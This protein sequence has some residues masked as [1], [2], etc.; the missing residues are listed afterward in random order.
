MAL[1]GFFRNKMFHMSKMIRKYYIVFFV[2]PIFRVDFNISETNI[3]N[4][5]IGQDRI[6][7]F[8]CGLL[9]EKVDTI[10]LYKEINLNTGTRG[11]IIWNKNNEVHGVKWV[12]NNIGETSSGMAINC[13]VKLKSILDKYF[14]NINEIKPYSKSPL[15][16]MH[17]FE[18]VIQSNLGGKSKKIG[19]L[20]SQLI[21]DKEFLSEVTKLCKGIIYIDE[22]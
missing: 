19:F 5:S 9:S 21:Y 11:L 3:T 6:D 1:L 17:D 8:Y 15:E 2:I 13:G 22:E 18:I 12:T 16:T 4:I 14:D 20:N 7:S 10:F